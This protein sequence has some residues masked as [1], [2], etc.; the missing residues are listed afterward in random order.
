[1][2]VALIVLI[3]SLEAA[4]LLAQRG[5]KSTA[6]DLFHAE[7]GLIVS[8]SE[9]RRSRFGAAKKSVIAVTLGLRYRISKIS[10][11]QVSESDPSGP[12]QAGDQ[13]RLDVEINDTGYLYIVHRQ[14]D[15]KWRRMFPN[16][17]IEQG[18]HF[19]RSGV[20]YPVPPEEGVPLQFAGGAERF[21]V[22]LSREPLKELEVLVGPRQ[23][24]N[25]VSAAP[26]PEI[27]EAVVEK[28]RG[29]VNK[30]DLA[31]D[32][33]AEEKAIY[34]VNRSGRQDSIVVVE[35]RLQTP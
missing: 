17:E 10:G 11:A 31:V 2:P 35:I 15:G 24:E 16:P 26:P 32:R 21:F 18:N 34:A 28:V 3:L 12:F 23:P 5:G 25:T 1:M 14:P 27:A 29:M 9:S 22:V 30:R 13:I 19:V 4:P 20:T 33:A 7:A 6:R 8:P